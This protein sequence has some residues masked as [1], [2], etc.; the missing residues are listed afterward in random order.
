MLYIKGTQDIIKAK[1]TN[2]CGPK[3]LISRSELLSWTLNRRQYLHNAESIPACEMPKQNS[4]KR[5][6][7]LWRTQTGIQLRKQTKKHPFFCC[8]ELL[9]VLSFNPTFMKVSNS[10]KY[11]RLRKSSQKFQKFFPIIVL[12]IFSDLV[13]YYSICCNK[14]YQ[15]QNQLMHN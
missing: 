15:E 9:L 6:I 14:Q 4:M 8:K 7:R 3:I 5:N 11:K 12:H 2:I 13:G 1:S 10:N